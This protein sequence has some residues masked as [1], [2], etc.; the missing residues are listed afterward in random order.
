V[1]IN[2]IKLICSCRKYAL[3]RIKTKFRI[4]EWNV[5]ELLTLTEGELKIVFNKFP[6]LISIAENDKIRRLLRHLKYLDFTVF[7]FNN[8][9]YDYS[10]IS[11][12][13]FK[14]RIENML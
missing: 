2:N 7:S 3:E 4:Y 5:I 11:F 12:V 14:K 1:R 13:D 8:S 9:N 10:K 6:N